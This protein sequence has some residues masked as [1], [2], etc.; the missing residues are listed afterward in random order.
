MVGFSQT[1]PSNLTNYH[2]P[3][4][5]VFLVK[6]VR[7]SHANNMPI[8][9]IYEEFFGESGTILWVAMMRWTVNFPSDFT[10]FTPGLEIKFAIEAA[11]KN[12]A[13]VHFAGV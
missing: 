7:L 8:K 11:E 1:R 4:I 10:P 6:L 2:R 12:K 9:T 5:K 13:K 3:K